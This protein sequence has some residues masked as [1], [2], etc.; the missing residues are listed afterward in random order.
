MAY[1]GKKPAQVDV[2]LDSNSI[3][4]VE[5]AANSVYASEIANNAITAAEL[6]TNSIQAL[7]VPNATALVL[8]GGLTV[9][10]IT[11][12]GTE[13]DL[14]SGDLTVDVAGDIYLDADGGD[15][16]FK[17]GGTDF[18]EFSSASNNLTIK[19]SISDADI[20]F[21]G[22][23]GGSTINALTL[24]MSAAGAATFN[25]K[26][27]AT[28][29]D[30]SGNV[31]IDGVLETDNLTVG[32]AQGSDGQ[33]LT[34]TGSGVAWEDASGAVTAVNNATA[35]EL[36]T[37]GSTTTELDAEA[38][39]TFDG[40]TL[41]VQRTL[42]SD[43]TSSPDTVLSLS[44]K[45]TSTGADGAAGAG[46]RLLFKVPDDS[47]N[48]QVGASIDAVKSNADDGISDTA[49]VFSTSQNDATLDEAMRIDKDGNVVIGGGTAPRTMGF[50]DTR[51]QIEGVDAPTGSLSII[52]NTA[53]NNGP[54][55][56]FGKSRGGSIGSNTVVQDG[57]YLGHI[58]FN[59][60]DGTDMGNV[61]AEIRGTVDGTP[62][63]DDTPGKLE[64]RTTADGSNSTTTRMTI[65]SDGK[66]G[67]NDTSPDGYLHTTSGTAGVWTAVFENSA[68]GGAGVLIKSAGATGSENILDVRNGSITGFK[69]AQS[70]GAVTCGGPLN[71]TGLT[72]LS[73]N[74]TMMSNTLY[75]NQ[76]Y[77]HDRLGHLN[78]ADTYIDFADDGI[79]F[80]AGGAAAYITSSQ[81]LYVGTS[82]PALAGTLS[83][84]AENAGVPVIW[85][86][87]SH[88]DSVGI[89]AQVANNN[90]GNY[91]F[92]AVNS[93]GGQWL[94]RNDGDHQGTDT[95]IGSLSDSRLK[96]DVSDLTYDINKFK[97]Y[98]PIEFN[99]INP[100]LHRSAS[101]KS[102]GFLAQEVKALDEYYVDQY[103]AEGADLSLVDA[104]KK[105][106][107]TKFGYKDAMYISVI[108]QLIT[109]LETAEAKIAVLEG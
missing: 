80:A 43:T 6:A 95:S 37:I 57:D 2:A 9:D 14:S 5:M 79:T 87:N 44:T 13:I 8:D 86:K 47:T 17:D 15:I 84:E 97:Q 76:A 56:I 102:R 77:V 65:K 36:V 81:K 108:K 26:I 49:L 41:V 29:L 94:I 68:N 53:N 46:S 1:I 89:R 58:R 100:E 72:T 99:W 101:G 4:A 91:I 103:D 54:Y 52:R 73:G 60:A 11:I 62:G 64:L 83:V 7:H 98:R 19:S 16:V 39:L 90:A 96:K 27:I 34:S 23:D 92:Y 74:L 109:R 33:V 71:V 105:A 42:S 75:A 10:N 3:T 35:N 21:N 106:F 12:D 22:N 25:D 32:G 24:D 20:K 28:E 88:A 66:V 51:T 30:I 59:G 48:P 31:D 61:A 38:N 70:D 67:I 55:I 18:G 107:S 82:G 78:D 45:Y 104:D 93:G 63:A 50:G 85:A 69:V 40:S